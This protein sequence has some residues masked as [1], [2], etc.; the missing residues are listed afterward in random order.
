MM[1]SFYDS[2]TTLGQVAQ[3]QNLAFN[4]ML[5]ITYIHYYS[6]D[7]PTA[8][9][10]TAIGSG[11]LQFIEMSGNP[12]QVYDLTFHSSGILSVEG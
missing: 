7:H 5:W 4:I 10:F 9:N 2:L 1:N 8:T 11:Q 3:T 6:V 12:Y